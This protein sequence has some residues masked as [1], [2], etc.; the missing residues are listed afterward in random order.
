MEEMP[1]GLLEAVQMI[2]A[3]LYPVTE[4]LLEEQAFQQRWE[5]GRRWLPQR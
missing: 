1:A 3:F 5:P 2:A 4:A